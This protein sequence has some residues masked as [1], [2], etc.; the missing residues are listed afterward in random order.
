MAKRK[1]TARRSSPRRRR[2]SG[3]AGDGFETALLSVGGAVAGTLLMQKLFPTMKGELKAGIVGV[4]GFLLPQFVK[5]KIGAGLG[6]GMVVAAGLSILKELNVIAGLDG[7]VFAGTGNG[8]LSLISG[9]NVNRLPFGESRNISVMA[10]M[11]NE[12]AALN[13]LG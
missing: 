7:G 4:G 12:R 9:S 3:V 5:G 10:G 2:M 1:K 8:S 13:N 11:T 6:S